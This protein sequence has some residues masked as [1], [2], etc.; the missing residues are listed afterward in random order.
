M[1]QHMK[2]LIREIVN[3]STQ[4]L[5]VTGWRADRI[6]RHIQDWHE[7]E[8]TRE[9]FHERSHADQDNAGEDN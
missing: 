9:E 7:A 6:A 3:L 4:G 2:D 5:T 8:T 1:D